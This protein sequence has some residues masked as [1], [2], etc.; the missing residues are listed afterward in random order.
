M[1]AANLKSRNKLK[2]QTSSLLGSEAGQRFFLLPTLALSG[3]IGF[4]GSSGL[5]IRIVY[6]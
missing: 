1:A 6:G 2:T 5:T 4:P 3:A